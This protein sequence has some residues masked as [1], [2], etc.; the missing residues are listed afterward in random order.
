MLDILES[1]FDHTIGYILGGER[2]SNSNEAA[3][4]QAAIDWE[5]QKEGATTAWH[6][7]QEAAAQHYEREQ[8]LMGM[9]FGHSAAESK[10][11]RDWASQESEKAWKRQYDLYKNRYVITTADMKNAG[12]NPILAAT[13]GFNVGSGMTAP[14]ASAGQ[15]SAAMGH[16]ATAHAPAAKSNMARTFMHNMPG[17]SIASSARDIAH[18][19]DLQKSAEKKE[20]EIGKIQQDTRLVTNQTMHEMAKI[21]FTRQQTE[22]SGKQEQYYVTAADKLSREFHKLADEITYI[23]TQTESLKVGMK[24]KLQN[25]QQVKTNIKRME[26]ITDTLEMYQ[27]KLKAMTD[28]YDTAYGK[29][30][31]FLRALSEAFGMNAGTLVNTIKMFK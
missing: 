22:T 2:Q 27:K 4:Q 8:S 16:A 10:E 14:I 30:L 18:M 20:A 29:N 12:L 19:K 3:A 1:I 13:G 31:Q 17:H 5:R 11:Y 9:Q 23:Q 7:S 28:V 15:A 6:R 26:T 24:E 21:N 25:I